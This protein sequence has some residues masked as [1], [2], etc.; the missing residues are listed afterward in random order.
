MNKLSVQSE[1]KQTKMALGSPIEN[2]SGLSN[3]MNFDL[4][5]LL[6]KTHSFESK[7]VKFIDLSAD[8]LL[9][10]ISEDKNDQLEKVD[11]K[12]KDDV[13]I[14]ESQEALLVCANTKVRKA[15]LEVKLSDLHVELDSIKPSSIPPVI[16]LEEKNGISVKLH[17]ARDKPRDGISV[18][19]VTMF[20]RSEL[21]LKNIL[22]RAIVP[23]V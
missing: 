17:F 21:P 13:K 14:D 19:V 15:K 10:D 11:G 8:D 6:E 7:F 9:V 22:F 16:V 1:T 23:K 12:E 20:S 2:M 18:I 4:S 5:Y 3:P